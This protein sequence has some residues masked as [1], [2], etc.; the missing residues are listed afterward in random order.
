MSDLVLTWGGAHR[1]TDAA[2]PE[3]RAKAVPVGCPKR[4]FSRSDFADFPHADVPFIAVFENLH[5]RRY[6]DAYRDRFVRDLAA[7]AEATP[8]T[9]FL[10]KPHMGG[11]WFVRGGSNAPLPSNVE[12]AHP[13]AARWRRF[14]ADAFLA[15]A[16]A[17]ITTPSTIALDAARYG[18]PAALVTYGI[19]AQNYHPLPRLEQ[20]GDWLTFVDQI[21][22]GAYDRGQLDAFFA[23]AVVP[24]DAVARILTVIRSAGA[25][26]SPAEVLS[27]LQ[28]GSH[29]LA[30]S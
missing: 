16:S 18:V 13:A 28:E 25:R 21:R 14:T 11:Q 8:E 10:V 15:H 1:L 6:N 29:S 26:R 24:G 3:V 2:A 27:A 19:A 22:R 4:V 5:W 12:I 20:A 17:V 23:D 7:T 30:A 9:R